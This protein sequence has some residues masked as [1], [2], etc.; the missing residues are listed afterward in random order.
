MRK[1]TTIR[2]RRNQDLTKLGNAVT[3]FI[4]R[5][6]IMKITSSSSH[7]TIR[8]TAIE[9]KERK[10]RLKEIQEYL[11]WRRISGRYPPILWNVLTELPA[12]RWRWSQQPWRTCSYGAGQNRH[13]KISQKVNN[14][15]QHHTKWT[16]ST[17]QNEATNITTTTRLEREMNV[18]DVMKNNRKTCQNGKKPEESLSDRAQ[19]C[20]AL[21]AATADERKIKTARPQHDLHFPLAFFFFSFLLFCLRFFS[22]SRRPNE[23]RD[24]TLCLF[25]YPF[26]YI[27]TE[28]GDGRTDGW[29][30]YERVDEERR[31]AID[32]SLITLWSQRQWPRWERSA[33]LNATTWR[34]TIKTNTNGKKS[35]DR[36]HL[37]STSSSIPIVLLLL[38]LFI[39]AAAASSSSSSWQGLRTIKSDRREEKTPQAWPQITVHGSI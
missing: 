37:Y 32:I 3:T 39:L 11:R 27:P 38:T 20:R 24:D 26:L 30:D 34:W 2:K 35:L 23:R 22:F 36:D 21:P 15:N 7:D 33:P 31:L 8:I 19:D 17:T 25:F 4:R 14:N 29:M 12:N 16:C 28:R 6:N 13:N 9:M 5:R 1:T 10:K 18:F